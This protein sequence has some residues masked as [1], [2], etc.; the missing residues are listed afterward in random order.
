MERVAT[1]ELPGRL[2]CL[3][4]LPSTRPSERHSVTPTPRDTTG[5]PPC[6]VTQDTRV[7]DVRHRHH[8]R[9]VQQ[10]PIH[11]GGCRD[12][13]SLDGSADGRQRTIL[14]A[15]GL[16]SICGRF[17]VDLWSFCG[18]F[19]VD[20][21]SICGHFVVILWSIICGHFVAILWSICGHFV[22]DLWSITGRG[23][24]GTLPTAHRIHHPSIHPS[25]KTNSQPQA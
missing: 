23:E 22:V 7:M 17:V 4:F 13:H 25:I 10:N 1:I 2:L 8:C 6:T 14:A 15:S 21:W 24:Y 20:L 3:E 5:Y 19:V 16:W 12:G 11:G 9:S 18:R